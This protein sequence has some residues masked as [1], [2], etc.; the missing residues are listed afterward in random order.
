MDWK[1]ARVTPLLKAGNRSDMGNYRP[2]SVLP[3]MGKVLERVVHDQLYS[4]LE[5]HNLLHPAQSGF[6]PAHS[7]ITCTLSVLNDIYL[8]FDKKC[9]TG[10][11]FLDLKR[12]LTLS[13]TPY[14][15]KNW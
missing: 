2:I 6:R 7:T 9:V 15:V 11:V 12:R 14:F 13:T 3:I 10:A 4:F 1:I 5:D 8:G